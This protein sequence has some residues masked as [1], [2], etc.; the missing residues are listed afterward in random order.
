M[1]FH[2]DILDEL[3]EVISDFKEVLR[4]KVFDFLVLLLVVSSEI[5]CYFIQN[6]E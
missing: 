2:L 5:L 3:L 6:Y 4:P 1:R